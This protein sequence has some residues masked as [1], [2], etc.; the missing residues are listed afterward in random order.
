MRSA[1]VELAPGEKGKITLGAPSSALGA[2]EGR[3][4]SGGRPIEGAK[5]MILSMD[6]AHRFTSAPPTAVFT[7]QEGRFQVEGLPGGEYLIWILAQESRGPRKSWTVTLRNG[8][9][10]R[11]EAAFGSCVVEGR[12]LPKGKCR[13]LEGR[14]VLL[15]KE[16]KTVA[17]AVTDE[18]GRFRMKYLNPGTYQVVL[19]PD[20]D[21]KKGD[22]LGALGPIQVGGTS[23][24]VKVTLPVQGAA[25]LE[26]RVLPAPGEKLEVQVRVEGWKT[27]FSAETDEKGTFRIQGIPPGR[28]TLVVQGK[29]KRGSARVTTLPGGTARVVLPLEG[30]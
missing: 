8:K 30:Q 24:L 3:V 23:R 15:M 5:V 2:L 12:L 11:L 1:L 14:T 27:A 22:P 21:T 20:P 19:Q 25:A 4:T 26:G 10:T 17:A 29:G 6:P 7:D 16:G 9:R 28:T 13:S 18:E